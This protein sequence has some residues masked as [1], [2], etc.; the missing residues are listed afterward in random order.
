MAGAGRVTDD[1]R[2]ELLADLAS[3]LSALVLQLTT[4]GVPRRAF[5]AGCRRGRGPPAFESYSESC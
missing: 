3:R 1:E 4:E 2:R 5:S